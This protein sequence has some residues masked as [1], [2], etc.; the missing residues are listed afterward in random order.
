VVGARPHIPLPSLS[1][2]R[3]CPAA[4]LP[5]QEPEYLVKWSGRAHIHNEWLRESQ[6]L[7]MAR[8]KLLNFKKRHGEVHMMRFCYGGS[9]GRGGWVFVGPCRMLLNF[10]K[11]HGEVC[12]AGV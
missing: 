2:S 9:G 11:R 12:G 5:L 6:L 4:P 3:P 7:G 8:R 1:H 10:K